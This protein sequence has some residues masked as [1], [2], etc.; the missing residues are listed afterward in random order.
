MEKEEMLQRACIKVAQEA[1]LLRKA[2]EVRHGD[3][4]METNP[5][6]AAS[7]SSS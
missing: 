2:G 4:T 1:E 6:R 5:V 7:P 3:E